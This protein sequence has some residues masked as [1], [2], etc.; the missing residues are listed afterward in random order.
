LIPP[1]TGAIFFDAVGTLIHPR[2]GA[3][4]VYAEVGQRFGS[5]YDAA[6]VARRFSAAFQLR[7]EEDHRE[8]WQTD[9]ERELRRW[10]EIVAEVLDDVNDR[11]GCF[12]A[13]YE[14]F[15]RPAS[16]GCSAE[17][18]MVLRELARHGLVLGMASNFD[19]RLRHVAAGLPELKPL[20]HLVI[21][22]E[23]GWRK[24]APGFFT[25][26]REAACLPSDRILFIGDHPENDFDGARAAGMRALLFDPNNRHPGRP[27]LA[28]LA[29][30][31]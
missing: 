1:D 18:G 21:S 27:R 29:E 7:E 11:A 3:A 8:G 19:E 2:P 22:A 17:A 28:G 26:V 23:V 16:W 25:A 6:A 5:R 20:R 10:R 13:L 12:A 14:H 9:E 24:P 30:L 4:W 15:R 31:L